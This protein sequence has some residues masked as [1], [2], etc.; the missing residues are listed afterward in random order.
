MAPLAVLGRFDVPFLFQSLADLELREIFLLRPIFLHSARLPVFRHELRRLH[1]VRFP[2]KIE[3]LVLGA[4]KILRA[5]VTFQAPRHAVGLRLVDR[6]HV[7]YL[8]VTNG[9][10]DSPIHV[11]GVI[12]KDIIGRPMN[13]HPLDRFARLPTVA[14]RLKLRVILL[15]LRVAVH[16]G[17]RVWQVRVR[18]HFDKTVAIPAIHPEL[19]H[20]NVVGK[21]HRLDWLVTDPRI[22]WRYVVPGC[23][24]QAAGEHDRTDRHFQRQ[25]VRPARKKV[26]HTLRGRARA[27]AA[28]ARLRL[29][30]SAERRL[31]RRS[32]PQAGDV[33]VDSRHAPDYGLAGHLKGHQRCV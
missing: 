1:V 30:R 17:L 11:R 8:A 12:V 21:R 14:H 10:T 18:R 20:M 33:E 13:L 23:A 3:N 29:E 31:S 25:P 22:F 5:P 4:Q 32:A 2:V 28:P 26:R 9:T 7:I 16:A 15:H 6:R 27:Q 24:G 19:R